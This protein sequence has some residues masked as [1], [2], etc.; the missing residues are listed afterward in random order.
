M[1][2]R[3]REYEGRAYPLPVVRTPD[4]VRGIRCGGVEPRPQEDAVTVYG[5]CRAGLEPLGIVRYEVQPSYI[6]N[7]NIRADIDGERDVPWWSNPSTHWFDMGCT[8][9]MGPM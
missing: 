5:R 7:I 8:P 6:T 1:S 9:S 4:A 2:V 3:G